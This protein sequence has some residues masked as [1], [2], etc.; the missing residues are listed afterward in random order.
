[1][2]MVGTTNAHDLVTV[3]TDGRLCSWSV[4]N[5]QLPIEA[6]NLTLAKNKRTVIMIPRYY[7]EMN[8]FSD[9]R[10]IHVIL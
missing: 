4:D 2:Q 3:S 8:L 6:M 5:L 1:M 9:H 10:Y 7:V